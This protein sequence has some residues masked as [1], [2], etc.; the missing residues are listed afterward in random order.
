MSRMNTMVATLALGATVAFAGP[1][2]AEK[3]KATLDGKSEVPPNA[4][5]AKGTADIDYDAATKKNLTE[6]KQREYSRVSFDSLPLDLA[7]KRVKGTGARKLAIFSDPDCPYCRRLEAEI[8]GLSDVTIYTF[9]MPIQSLHPE[10]RGKARNY[11]SK[12]WRDRSP[13]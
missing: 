7:F 3:M 12:L 9:L 4:S 8:K 10:A 2:F 13:K 11:C 1:A 6:A 5:A